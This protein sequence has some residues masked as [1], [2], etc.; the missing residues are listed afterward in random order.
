MEN[1]N[2]FYKISYENFKKEIMALDSSLTEDTAR[3][4]YEN[5]KLPKRA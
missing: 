4:I 5:I 3:D 1:K 2:K